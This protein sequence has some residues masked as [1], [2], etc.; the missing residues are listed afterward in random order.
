[1]KIL[2]TLGALAGL[3]AAAYA[4]DDAD[5]LRRAHEKA[6]RDLEK[7]QK[8]ERD[9][10]ERKFAEQAEKADKPRADVEKRIED[11]L[12]Q[13]EKLAAEVRKLQ[14]DVAPAKSKAKAVVERARKVIEAVPQK[15][16]EYRIVPRRDGDKNHYEFDLEDEL[17]KVVPF[18]KRI[19]EGDDENFWYEFR[20]GDDEPKVVPLPKAKKKIV[21]EEDDER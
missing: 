6:M 4:Q 1:M 7:R 10:L 15:N 5:S 17:K 9:A 2:I 16:F 19:V 13:I 20:E 11:L 8:A 14:A 3:S 12:R 18:K 21:V